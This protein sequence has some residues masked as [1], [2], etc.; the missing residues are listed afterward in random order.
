MPN[1][2]QQT[3]DVK[4]AKRL[5]KQQRRSRVKEL[6]REGQFDEDGEAFKK[7]FDS[8]LMVRM[9]R[10]LKPYMRQV[11]AAIILL[12]IYSAIVPIFP[13]LIQLSI[14]RF[15]DPVRE[16]FLSLTLVF[17]LAIPI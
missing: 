5:F 3:Y 9:L 17:V 16:P 8:E 12:F 15:I 2:T 4:D 14:D 7:A 6:R 13:F 1:S 11:F 10:Y